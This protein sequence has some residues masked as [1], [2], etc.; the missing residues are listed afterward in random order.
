MLASL[1]ALAQDADRAR[2][3]AGGRRR[4]RVP[5]RLGRGR[6]RRR[7]RT[8]RWSRGGPARATAPTTTSRWPGPRGATCCSSTTT[9]ACCPGRSTRMAAHLDAPPGRRRRRADAACAPTAR[10]RSSSV[11]DADGAGRRAGGAAARPR[12][13]GGARRRRRPQPVGWAMGCALLVAPRRRRARLGGFDEGYFMYSE[14]VDLCVRLAAAG[15]VDALGARRPRSSTTGRAPRAT[16][17]SARSRWPARAAATSERH[18]SR[19]GR[20]LAARSRIGAQFA[21]ARAAPRCCAAGPRARSR[22]RPSAPGGEPGAS[23]PARAGRG[24]QPGAAAA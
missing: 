14:E 9:R 5:G 13:P 18:Y 12:P 7:S 11:A 21:D 10:V 6:A 19:A 8:S 24:V 2:A 3:A 16:R 4:Q 1:R 15:G 22:C 23:R 17:P 20:R